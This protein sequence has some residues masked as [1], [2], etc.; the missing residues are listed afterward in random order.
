MKKLGAQ[1]VHGKLDR[2]YKSLE[3]LLQ[4]LLECWTRALSS[5]S[6]NDALLCTDTLPLDRTSSQIPLHSKSL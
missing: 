4:R 1:R 2:R 6:F 5:P 3:I